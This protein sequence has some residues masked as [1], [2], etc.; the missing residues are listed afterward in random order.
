VAPAE[1]EGHLLLHPHVRDACVV[2]IPDE[3]SGEVPLAFVVP[4]Q[5]TLTEIKKGKDGAGKVKKEIEKVCTML[6]P[7]L[8]S[9]I[10]EWPLFPSTCRM[11]RQHTSGSKAEWN[12]LMKCR[13]IQ[14][15]RLYAIF[16]PSTCSGAQSNFLFSAPS[17]FARE[18][19]N[20]QADATSESQVVEYL[21]Q[22]FKFSL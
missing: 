21:C 19:E 1:L 17:V 3:Y 6:F 13:R 8:L 14:L 18:G 12:L 2:G 11:R 16:W 7:I 9:L 20:S 10:F 15:E 4:S 5:S 22:K